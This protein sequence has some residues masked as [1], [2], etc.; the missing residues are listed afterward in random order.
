M[1]PL[2]LHNGDRYHQ[3]PVFKERRMIEDIMNS[4]WG[5]Y[6]V[7]AVLMGAIA[8]LLRVLYG[9]R[10]LFRD[11]KWDEE[12]QRIRSE[13]KLKRQ[14]KEERF[15]L[16]MHYPP[17]RDISPAPG[18]RLS[19]EEHCSLFRHYA[20]SFITAK[21]EDAPLRLKEVHSLRVFDHAKRIVQSEHFSENIARAGLLAALYHDCGRFPQYRQYR[22]FADALSV[23]H[24]RLSLDTLKKEHFLIGEEKEVRSLVQTAVLLHN[25]SS[26]PAKLLPEARLV[27]DMVRDA[28]KLDIISI[29]VSH[30]SQALPENDAVFLHVKDSPELCS[31]EVVQCVLAGRV[32]SYRELH[33]VNDFRLLLGT[34]MHELHFAATWKELQKRGDMEKV[35]SNLPDTPELR[36]AVLYLKNLMYSQ[37]KKYSSETV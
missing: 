10:G 6:I 34:W 22:T 9:P 25:K 19:L 13:E 11:P 17:A 28:D 29:M 12:N 26:L 23:N 27:T 4:R 8:L 7:M 32:V 15:Q 33:Y 18:H 5:G 1:P 31:P 2:A 16:D 21:E 37:G 35:L 24:A 36:F 14:W 20:A 3:P 30:F